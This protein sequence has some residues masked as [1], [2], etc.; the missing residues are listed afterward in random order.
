LE[1]LLAAALDDAIDAALG[2]V[3]VEATTGESL[4]K[5]AKRDAALCKNIP[6][7]LLD[8]ATGSAFLFSVRICCS[9]SANIFSNS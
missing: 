1:G 6:T 5:D 7:A 9:L 4:K 2:V 3:L 8:S